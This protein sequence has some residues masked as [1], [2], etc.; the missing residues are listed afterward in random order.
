[1][2]KIRVTDR[3]FTTVGKPTRSRNVLSPWDCLISAVNTAIAQLTFLKVTQDF[4]G[5]RDHPA[6]LFSQNAQDFPGDRPLR[7]KTTQSDRVGEVGRR[8]NG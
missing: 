3:F 1:M 2:P 6:G 4:L 8:G 5:D 7:Y